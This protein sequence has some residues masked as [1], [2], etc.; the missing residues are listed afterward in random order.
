MVYTS[1]QEKRRSERKY[2]S[3]TWWRSIIG[4]L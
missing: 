1:S 3:D 2:Y 4:Y